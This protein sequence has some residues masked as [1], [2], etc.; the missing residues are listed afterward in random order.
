MMPELGFMWSS[1]VASRSADLPTAMQESIARRQ[2]ASTL[3]FTTLRPSGNFL[4]RTV[5]SF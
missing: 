1:S 4:G 5:N 2:A 3:A